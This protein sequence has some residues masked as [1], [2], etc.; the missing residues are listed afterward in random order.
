MCQVFVGE[1]VYNQSAGKDMNK[2]V[3][4]TWSMRNATFLNQ[5]WRVSKETFSEGMAE[6]TCFKNQLDYS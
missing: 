4:E 1:K 2:L 5:Y 3:L 6:S